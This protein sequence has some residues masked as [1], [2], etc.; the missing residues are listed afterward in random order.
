M[1]QAKK[2]Q[3]QPQD[4]YAQRG[5]A[6]ASAVQR[7]RGWV[8]SDPSRTPELADALVE[9]TEHRLLGHA[10]SAA[11]GD[12]QESVRLAAQLLT[13]N[14]PIGPYTSVTD[15]VRCITALVHF[16]TVQTGVGLLP[17]ASQTIESVQDLRLQLED[18]RPEEQ[19]KPPTAIWALWCA[20]RTS[21]AAGD[22]AGANAHADA[23]LNRVRESGLR[24]EGDGAYVVIDVDRV[25]SDAR[26]AAGRVDESL[27]LAH[28]AKEVYDG[29]VDGRLRDPGRLSPAL[30]ERLAEPLFGLYRDLADRL[31]ATGDADLALATRRDLVE[32]LQG[33]G[34]RL[35]D[36]ARLP[37]AAALADLAEDLLLLDR[38]YEAEEATA[39]ALSLVAKRPAGDTSRMLV[40]AV[41]ARVLTRAARGGEAAT[42]L[43]QLLPAEVVTPPVAAQA[44]GLAALAEALRSN[45]DHEGAA[46]TEQTLAEVIQALTGSTTAS[47][48]PR[49]VVE[50]RARGVVSR[51][52]ERVSWT[53][54]SATA[55]YAATTS[56]LASDQLRVAESRSTQREH[57]Q[58]A[59]ARLEAE[60]A[61]AHER[62][63]ERSRQ[64]ELEAERRAAEQAEAD[65]LA[66]ERRS[67]ERALAERE[68][69]L[70][71]ERQAAAEEAERV[72][73][74][75]RR[76]ERLEAHR[77]EAE[78]IEAERRAASEPDELTAAEREWRDAQARG[79]RRSARTAN[80]HVVE[81][82]RP[83]AQADLATHGPRLRA[84]LEELSSAR[85]RSGDVW[86][87]RGPAREAK[88]LAKTLAR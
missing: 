47:A 39:E 3:R 34:G 54:L 25:A 68:A 40:A 46:S 17:A 27:S 66:A 26:W 71:A 5:K 15:A 43:H 20:A 10:Y 86:G 75:R 29:V 73:R 58:G 76:E 64:A 53:P 7:L 77:I 81:L 28:A 85:L 48:A 49:S 79:D 72:D 24:A 16:A 1:A 18:L 41:R 80:E 88:A 69:L 21:L 19:L 9:L 31:A 32:I 60:R 38:V 44:V 30:T 52:A 14:G 6:L 45:G 23:A 65:R 37:L 12:A 70:E 87:S 33:L 82:L 83:L 8:G 35:G 36:R 56:A 59:A 57:D 22:V 51:G 42:M 63:L 55:G 74:K 78:R 50:D 13:A 84:A 4:P 62:E 2:A 11:G 61:E 67:L